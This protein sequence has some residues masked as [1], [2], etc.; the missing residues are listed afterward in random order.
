MKITIKVVDV[1]LS[2]GSMNIKYISENSKN[3]IDEYESKEFTIDKYAT[4]PLEVINQYIDHIK[5]ELIDRDSLE[6]NP[7]TRPDYS[8][9]K[10]FSVELDV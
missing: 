6:E 10:D 2:V 9:W 7:I 4:G 3:G 5:T 8:T 1:N